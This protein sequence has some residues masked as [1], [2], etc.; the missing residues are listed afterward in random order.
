M[1]YDQH[2]LS[3][4]NAFKEHQLANQIYFEN[5]CVPASAP[6]EKEGTKSLAKSERVEPVR[7]DYRSITH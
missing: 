1:L 4:P 3:K 7:L 6:I 5:G 2:S